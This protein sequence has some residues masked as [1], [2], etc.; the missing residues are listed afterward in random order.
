MKTQNRYIVKKANKKMIMLHKYAKFTRNKSHLLQ[1]YQATWE[2]MA[3]NFARKSLKLVKFSKFFP[4]NNAKH[5]MEKKNPEKL[6][7]SGPGPGPRS[8][9]G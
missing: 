8:G 6:S 9:P 3:L 7:S 2:K 4:L 1:K 5:L